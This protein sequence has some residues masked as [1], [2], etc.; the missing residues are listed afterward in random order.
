MR[1][2]LALLLV[3]NLADWALTEDALAM[4]I[5]REGNPIGALMLAQGPLLSLI[6]KL[7]LVGV[8]CA[9]LWAL[10]GRRCVRAAAYACAAVYVA[11]LCWHVV[12][13]L[14]VF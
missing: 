13:R 5:A 4:G 3:C 14:L 11:L 10:R 1:T 8:A 7:G 9:V 6:L 12:G 2:A